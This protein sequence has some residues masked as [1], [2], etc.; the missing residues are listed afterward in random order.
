MKGIIS[1]LALSASLA[2]CA[3]NN[4][5]GPHPGGAGY[6]PDSAHADPTYRGPGVYFGGGFGRWGGQ[7]GA[8]VGFGLGF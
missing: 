7:R 2:G 8:G 5:D 1:L 6:P 4:P 3:T